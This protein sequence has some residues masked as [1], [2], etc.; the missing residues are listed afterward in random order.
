MKLLLRICVFL[1]MDSKLLL[2]PFRLFFLTDT[3]MVL[4]VIS[5][6]YSTLPYL[7]LTSSDLYNHYIVS[8]VVL[9]YIAFRFYPNIYFPKKDA[10]FYL[11]C[12][13][14]IANIVSCLISG[15][16][17]VN[18]AIKGY[19]AY[20]LANVLTYILLYNIYIYNKKCNS[21]LESFNNTINGYFLFCYIALFCTF[22]M[23]IMVELFYFNPLYNDVTNTCDIFMAGLGTNRT[24]NETF[25]Y[26][27]YISVISV[28]GEERIDLFHSAGSIYGIFHEPHIMT[29][30]IFPVL[31]LI[32][33]KLKK[34]SKMI[35]V[36][37][38]LIYML[39]AVSAMNILSVLLLLVLFVCFRKPVLSVFILFF[40]LNGFF[41]LLSLDNPLVEFVLN[42]LVSGSA[43]YVINA[44]IYAFTPKSLFG[45]M[46]ILDT[47]Q[48]L[49]RDVNTMDIGYL[50]F[51]LNICFLFVFVYKMVKVNMS[52][53]KDI[54][55][56]G[57]SILYFFLHSFK[58]ITKNYEYTYLIF[59]IFI[60]N[61]TYEHSI[62][63]TKRKYID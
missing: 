43:E 57:L 31:F 10:L 38:F 1:D 30:M 15:A 5:L 61:I 13:V 44:I 56:I 26:P 33:I 54:R 16:V 53:D 29:F 21:F 27:Y 7:F 8:F 14:F 20:F 49:N 42:K 25:Y 24:A 11:Y 2:K 60:M 12:A 22:S 34:Y 40:A 32:L 52:K 51:L 19:P 55:L 39:C 4:L 37:V 58:L 18:T 36:V 45:N 3:I 46:S 28:G 48:F 9:L 41:L 35:I 23:L 59:M 47:N 62:C 17:I 6:T 63:K 50:V